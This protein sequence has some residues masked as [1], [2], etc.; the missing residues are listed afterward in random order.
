[1]FFN[2]NDI[3]YLICKF[4]IK[5]IKV[6][7]VMIGEQD[8]IDVIIVMDC[9]GSMQNWINVAKDTVIESFSHIQQKYTNSIIRLGLVC[10]RDFGDKE[11]FVISPLSENIEDTYKILKEIKAEG[12][13]DESE[14]VAGALEKTI[15]LFIDSDTYSVKNVLFVTDS[16]AHGLRYHHITVGDRFPN[17]D[18]YGREPYDQVKQLAFMGVDFT[19]FRVK[20]TVNIMI[21]ELQKA[22]FGTQSIFTVLDVENQNFNNFYSSSFSLSGFIDLSELYDLC[23]KDEKDEKDE[24][25]TSIKKTFKNAI[26]ESISSS[27]QKRY[28]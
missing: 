28:K 8:N 16:P 1:M 5:V 14:D 23:E 20:S 26:Y 4:N 13:N 22:F 3:Y 10:Y 27:F 18:P 24:K 9:T 19:I 11:Q 17:G 6:I 7:K 12:G 15:Q 2:T 21:E 25:E